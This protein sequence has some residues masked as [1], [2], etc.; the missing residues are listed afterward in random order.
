MR[1]AIEKDRKSSLV[2]G[3]DSST[4]NQ[5]LFKGERDKIS[6][7]PFLVKNK[8][9]PLPRLISTPGKAATGAPA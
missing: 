9:S 4:E 8:I 5:S 2:S 7:A 6:F 3:F 1:N